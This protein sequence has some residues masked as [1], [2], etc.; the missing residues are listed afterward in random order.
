M[1][2]ATTDDP[3][4]LKHLSIWLQNHLPQLNAIVFPLISAPDIASAQPEFA[5][6]NDS[7]STLAG[8]KAEEFLVKRLT[9]KF[10]S[11]LSN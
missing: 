6:L 8:R 5:K 7:L 2:E 11:Q 4:A 9:T 10:Q 3:S 1:R